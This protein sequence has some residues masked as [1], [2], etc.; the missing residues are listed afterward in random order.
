MSAGSP[1]NGI[2]RHR[3]GEIL[4]RHNDVVHP[5]DRTSGE[6]IFVGLEHIESHTGRRTGQLQID[7]AQLTGRKP[8]F[9]QG[10]IVYGYLRP[11]LNKVW[12]A[13]F[14]GC[15]SVDQFSFGVRS[16]LADTAFVAAFMRSEAFLRRSHIVTT[17]GQLPRI[18]VEEI[19]AVEIELPPFAV[20]RNIVERLRRRTAAAELLVQ[21]CREQLEAAE[22]LSASMLRELFP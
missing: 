22:A 1:A 14:D 21:R 7:L 5:G 18:G 16:E 10:Q 8:T 2:V 15:S 9:R 19:A 13:E 6:A 3:L 12:I 20:Q 11:Y 4:V 17:T